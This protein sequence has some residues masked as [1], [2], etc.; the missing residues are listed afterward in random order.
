MRNTNERSIELK[1]VNRTLYEWAI[2]SE[3]IQKYIEKEQEGIELLFDVFS[4]NEEKRNIASKKLYQL[5]WSYYPELGPNLLIGVLADFEH[6]RVFYKDYRNHTA[7]MIKV[8]LLGLYFYDS[9]DLIRENISVT[10]SG[11]ENFE[12]VWVLTALYHDIGYIFENNKI[13]DYENEWKEFK[14]KINEM[15]RLPMYYTF[16][17]KGAS[18]EK[19]KIFVKQ[20]R[21][22]RDEL[23]AIAEIDDKN[24]SAWDVLID[25]ARVT[26]LVDSSNNDKNGLQIYYN[27][28]EKQTG[29]TSQRPGYKDHGICSALILGKVWESYYEIT[30]EFTL[31][32]KPITFLDVEMDFFQ[33]LLKKEEII[34]DLVHI[35]MNAVA[36]HNVDKKSLNMAEASVSGINLDNFVI[37]LKKLPVAALLRICDEIQMWDREKYRTLNTDE[38]TMYA[39]ELDIWA[40]KESIYICFESDR[41]YTDPVGNSKSMYN[42][43][44]G[45]LHPYLGK[46]INDLLKYAG[47]KPEPIYD[48]DKLAESDDMIDGMEVLPKGNQQQEE[49]QESDRWLLGAVNQDEDVHFS[50][51]YLGQSIKYNLPE[52]LMKFGYEEIVAVYENF[53]ERYYIREKECINV[54]NNLISILIN[55]AEF[56]ENLSKKIKEALEELKDVFNDEKCEKIE[57][58]KDEEILSYYRK[59]YETHKQLYI[60]ARIPETLDRGVPSFTSFLKQYLKT[61]DKELDDEKKL[62]EVFEWLTYPENIN[63]TGREILDVNEISDK[64]MRSSSVQEQEMWKSSTG[65]FLMHMKPD[66]I[67]IIDNYVDT[68]KYWGYHGYRNRAVIDFPQV[69]ERFMNNYNDN[70]LKQRQEILVERQQQAMIKRVKYFSIY[71]INEKYQRLFLIYSQMG[72]L[73]MKRRYYQL[74]NFYFLDKII[75]E[76]AIR[77]NVEEGVIRCMLPKEVISLLDGNKEVLQKGKERLFSEVFIYQLG[78]DGENIICGKD[79]IALAKK[80][81]EETSF[82]DIVGSELIGETASLGEYQGYCWV[83][84]HDNNKGFQKGEILVATD[85]DPD[86][87]ELL[88]IA[89]AVITETGGFTCHAAIV[90]RELHI[91]CIVGVHG[92]MDK[93]CSGQKLFVDA[94]H[95]KIQILHRTN[96]GIIRTYDKNYINESEIGKKAYSL[97]RLKEAG[98]EVP[99]FFCIKIKELK[100]IMVQTDEGNAQRYHSF[101]VGIQDALEEL[102]SEW[103]AIRSSTNREDGEEV[104]GAGQEITMLRVHRTDVM[105]DLHHILKSLEDYDGSGCIIIQK[106]ILGSY[107]GV[108]FTDNPIRNRKELVIQAVP[109]GNEYLTSGKV[110]PVT[111]IFD[112]ETSE[113]SKSK[114]VWENLLSME[115]CERLKD[116]GMDISAFFSAPQDIE[117]TIQ[118]NKIYILQSRNITGGKKI[119]GN[120]I[121]LANKSLDIDTISIYQAYALP[122]HLR[123]HM[124]RVAALVCWIIDRWVGEEKLDKNKMIRASLLHDIG[125][126]VKGSDEKFRKIFPD[127][128][129]E[130]SWQYWLNVRDHIGKRYGTTDIEATLKIAN[131]INVGADVINLI[132]EKQFSNNVKIFKDSNFEVKICAYADQRISPD[133]VLSIRDRLN[134]AKRRQKGINNASVNKPNFEELKAC[135]LKIEEQIFVHIQGKPE[136]I[137]DSSIEEYIDEMKRF[138]F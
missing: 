88:K 91:P 37:D 59:H 54:A 127:T 55:D 131:E 11:E 69:L 9:V 82:D 96:D 52:E 108:I 87:Y 106:M 3:K 16:I 138:H 28:V 99:D 120:A 51:L 67:G 104:S 128:F 115:Q 101:L 24:N 89:G 38:R 72:S 121:F 105:Q 18:K 98:F 68:W 111:I 56:W 113:F 62:N 95:G 61:R 45:K 22:F 43:L 13:G 81:K 39:N 119:D 78:K 12:K 20:N 5:I 65:R 32:K 19:E 135:A 36:L 126:I 50:S 27:L 116:K 97:F 64:I 102:N 58:M 33:D 75:Q 130:G 94:D 15:L 63:Y 44:L 29:G 125:N 6:D 23:D 76:I 84:N 124:L 8:F 57:E 77:N 136:D 7:H 112:K 25:A 70:N 26:K 132:Q 100:D 31:C 66:V 107:S 1:G 4:M 46:A 117:W 14:E 49:E 109:G 35:A 80:M 86:K 118:E 134:E 17:N 110:N 85:L 60:Y 103:L 90:C 40:R 79:A 83:L 47:E 74:R 71:D 30:K 133:G 92:L 123:D 48:T 42:R 73:K 114:G 21:M 2:G 10:V 34:Q 137:T 53:N 129:S 122:K 93:V 41:E